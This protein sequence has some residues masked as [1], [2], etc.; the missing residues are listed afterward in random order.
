MSAGF[1]ELSQAQLTNELENV[2]VPLLVEQLHTRVAGHCMRVSYLDTEL[3]VRLGARL[4]AELPSVTVVVLTDGKL[5]IPAEF[6]VSSTKP[7]TFTPGTDIRSSVRWLPTNP[8]IPVTRMFITASRPISIFRGRRQPS[9][10]P[11]L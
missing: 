4:R 2:A 1:Q 9:S 6:A 5:P 10:S 7:D 8:S 3:M 11:A